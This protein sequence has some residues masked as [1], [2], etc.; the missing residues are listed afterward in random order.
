MKILKRCLGSRFLGKP[1]TYEK[2]EVIEQGEI[3]ISTCILESGY[4]I[5]AAMFP[6]FAYKRGDA[7]AI[8]MGDI[9]YS[10]DFSHPNVIL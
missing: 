5:T 2:A 1:E 10:Q 7:W 8:P 9:R 6:E 4:A 3:R